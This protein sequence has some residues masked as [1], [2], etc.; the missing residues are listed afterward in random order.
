MAVNDYKQICYKVGTTVTESPAKAVEVFLRE[1]DEGGKVYI[2]LVFILR[3]RQNVESWLTQFSK[4]VTSGWDKVKGGLQ[5]EDAA[6][7]L[8]KLSVLEQRDA[9][10]EEREWYEDIFGKVSLSNRDQ[11]ICLRLV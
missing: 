4:G 8:D 5:F 6:E 7:F 1:S 11:F 9:T 10:E 2:D 3:R